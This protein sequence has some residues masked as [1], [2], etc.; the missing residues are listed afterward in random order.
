VIRNAIQNKE[1]IEFTYRGY[2][3]VAEPHVYGIKDDKRQLIVYQTGGLASSG[4]IE[5]WRRI[6]LEDISGLKLAGGKFAGQ[7]EP[8]PSDYADWDTIIST[9][10]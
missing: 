9:V 1:V 4:R 8:K 2:P 6:N 3:R 10:A 7:R 5:G